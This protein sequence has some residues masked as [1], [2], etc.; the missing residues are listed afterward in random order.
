MIEKMKKLILAAA[1]VRRQTL[2]IVMSLDAFGNP[3]GFVSDIKDSF[4]VRDSD[5]MFQGG[6]KMVLVE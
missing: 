1:E 6:E 5:S 3:Q 2:N 4:Q